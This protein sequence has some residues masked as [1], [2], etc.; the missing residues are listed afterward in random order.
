MRTI[1]GLVAVLLA[2]GGVATVYAQ[3]T[4][5]SPLFGASPKQISFTE[6]NP[7]RAMGRPA[8]PFQFYNLGSF[9][10]TLTAPITFP[11]LSGA[12]SRFPNTTGHPTPQFTSDLPTYRVPGR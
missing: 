10:R 2:L 11:P 1:A 7:I 5:P 4:G 9:F 12:T 3:Q 8:S 6:I